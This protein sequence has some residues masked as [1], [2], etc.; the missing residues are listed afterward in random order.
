MIYSRLFGSFGIKSI[1]YGRVKVYNPENFFFGSYSTLNEGCILNARCNVHVGDYVHISPNVI[2]NTGG[3][4][5]GNFLWE[6]KHVSSPIVIEDGV[7][8]GAGAI[9]NPGVTIGKNSVVGSGAVVT[10]NVP[11]CVVVVGVPAKIMKELES[12]T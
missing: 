3:L 5:Y 2:I 7:W 8:I 11:P 10:K 12:C 9:I 1:I 6:R 4:N